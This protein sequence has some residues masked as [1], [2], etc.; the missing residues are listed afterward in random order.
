LLALHFDNASYAARR[1]TGFAPRNRRASPG[2]LTGNHPFTE[3][4][5]IMNA[6]HLL[7][8]ALLASVVL[9]SIGCTAGAPPAT[10]PPPTDPPA[11]TAP[12]LPADGGGGGGTTGDTGD[13]N[14]PTDVQPPPMEP[15]MND[16]AL[17]VQP[18]PGI[19]DARPHAWD[20]ISVAADGRTLTVYYW[21]GV[22]ECYGLAGVDVQADDQ[23]RPVVRVFEGRRGNL[24]PDTACIEIA[25]L[26]AV[27]VELEDPIIASSE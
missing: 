19:V 23:G 21:G 24:P 13:P 9:S 20:R 22:E 6:R 26:K 7:S 27:E 1:A 16:G 17:H 5:L 11:A 18:Q 2:R 12:E 14:A 10:E 4:C 15:G 25:L 8:I 3:I